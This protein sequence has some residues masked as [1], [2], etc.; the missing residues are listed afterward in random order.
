[1]PIELQSVE[2]LKTAVNTIKEFMQEETKESV[3][4]ADT[5]LDKMICS[6][7]LTSNR[8]AFKKLSKEETIAFFETTVSSFTILNDLKAKVRQKDLCFPD[9]IHHLDSIM[10]KKA[11]CFVRIVYE[12]VVF[13]GQDI[14]LN[15]EPF[16]DFMRRYVFLIHPTIKQHASDQVW[17][18]YFDKYLI[19]SKEVIMI[20]LRNTSR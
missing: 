15:E 2:T 13:T 8:K 10:E 11:C 3:W 14:L 16:E 12:R 6:L 20:S 19:M 7:P 9:L 17:I 4:A 1:M 18:D 5:F